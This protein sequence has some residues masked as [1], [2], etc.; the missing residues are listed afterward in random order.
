MGVSVTFDYAA[1]LVL[2]PEFTNVVLEPQA[3]AFFDAAGMFWR[4][5]GTSPARTAP[6]QSVLMNYLTAHLAKLFGGDAASSGL[7]G[8]ISSA[9][10]GSVSV[11]VD[12]PTT[13]AN[14]WF[15]QTTYGAV[16]WQMT[17]AYR[18]MRYAAPPKRGGAIS[19][20]PGYWRGG[21]I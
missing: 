6:V 19:P 5:D 21:S 9:S 14:A 20:F 3:Q 16:F 11:S 12:W 18:T 15:L 17:A 4:N 10:E 13:N 1:W 8:R 7:V 2:F